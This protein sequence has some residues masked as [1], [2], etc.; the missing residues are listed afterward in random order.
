MGVIKRADVGTHARDAIAM[1]LSDVQRRADAVVLA[2]QARP[3][4]SSSV[5]APSV[6]G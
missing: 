4:R 6:S 5:P 2:A 1:D 3:A